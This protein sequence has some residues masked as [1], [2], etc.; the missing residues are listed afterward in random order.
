[1]TAKLVGDWLKCLES[2]KSP[3][4]IHCGDRKE[5]KMY[6]LSKEVAGV[7]S[8]HFRS[9][10][11]LGV[12]AEVGLRHNSLSVVTENYYLAQTVC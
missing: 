7:S 5:Q 12:S 11:Y 2:G 4:A 6:V 9:R 8:H 1:M 10:S 3:C